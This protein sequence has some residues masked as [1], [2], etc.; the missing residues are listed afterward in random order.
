MLNDI[1]Y[2]CG[3]HKFFNIYMLRVILF[4]ILNEINSFRPI[5]KISLPN[6]K[7]IFK[8]FFKSNFLTLILS[9]SI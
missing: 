5:F 1:N 4:L 2:G 8:L 6:T 7:Q 9:K 3:S